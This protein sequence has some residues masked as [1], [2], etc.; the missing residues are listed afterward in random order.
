[1]AGRLRDG[2]R[3]EILL[4]APRPGPR[5]EV[6]SLTGRNDPADMCTPHAWSKFSPEETLP[7]SS[8]N[9]PPFPVK[10]LMA[11]PER[12]TPSCQWTRG[13]LW[14]MLSPVTSRHASPHRA[15][16]RRGE[17][18]ACAS[19]DISALNDPLAASGD[20][21]ALKDSRVCGRE[22]LPSRPP[23]I[24]CCVCSGTSSCSSSSWPSRDPHK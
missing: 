21:G 22:P 16:K 20:P 15:E 1:M 10:T 7:F 23:I 9:L 11:P 14:K 24:I 2:V 12:C 18:A 19:S 4:M 8:T 3:G 17:A 6:A 5:A 13:P